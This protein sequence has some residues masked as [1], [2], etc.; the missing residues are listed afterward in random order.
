MPQLSKISIAIAM[1]GL[2]TALFMSQS[3]A[4]TPVDMLTSDI[5]AIDAQPVTTSA[6]TAAE[7]LKNTDISSNAAISSAASLSADTDK[8]GTDKDS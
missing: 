1:V 2:S 8:V 6:E 5:V 3:I 4:E 7:M